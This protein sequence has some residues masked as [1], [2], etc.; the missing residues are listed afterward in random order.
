MKKTVCMVLSIVL[1]LL[2]CTVYAEQTQES[3][4]ILFRNI[5]WGSNLPTALAALDGISFSDP[6]TDYACTVDYYILE[7]GDIKYTD[8]VCAKIYARSRS[9]SDMKVAGYELSGMN[10][11]FAFTTD[12]SGML[13]KDEEHTALAYADYE[14][15]PKD[16]QFVMND[17]L[18]KLTKTYG[19]PAGHRTT[20]RSITYDIYYWTGADGTIVSLVGKD[21]Q[22]G[23]TEVSIRYSFYGAEDLFQ[24]AMDALVYEEMLKTDTEDTSGL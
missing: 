16:L 5:P 4:P 11:L 2:T 9:I 12:D 18:G 1:C 20:G 21:Y 23:S 22:S 14:I 8:H 10:L 19:E 6:N 24:K 15:K 3:A 7:D 13:P 17:L